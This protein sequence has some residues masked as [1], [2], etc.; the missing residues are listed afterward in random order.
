[1]LTEGEHALRMT[2]LGDGLALD[3]IALVPAE[4]CEE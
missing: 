2:N 4:E 3:Y 1:M